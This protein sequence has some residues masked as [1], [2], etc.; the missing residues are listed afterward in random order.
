MNDQ[1]KSSFNIL[2]TGAFTILSALYI[3]PVLLIFFNSLK[4]ER[5]ITTETAFALPTAETFVGFENYINALS[6][7]G[8]AQSFFYSAYITVS[9][10]ALILLCCSMCAWYITRV[11]NKFSKGMYYIYAFSAWLCRS[12]W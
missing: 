10:V 11:N 2:L 5:S 9:G 1:K 3:Y 8:F 6:S 12:R 7:Q 4:E